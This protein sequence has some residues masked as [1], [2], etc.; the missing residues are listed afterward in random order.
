MGEYFSI[1]MS[2]RGYVYTWGMND[3]GQ[4]GI[5]SDVPYSFEPVAVSSSKSTLSKAVQ[6]IDCGL[7]HCLVLTKDYQLYSWGSNQLSQLGRKLAAQQNFSPQPGQVTAFEGTKPFKIACGSYHNICL[8]YRQPKQEEQETG[9]EE[10][11]PGVLQVLGQRS[12]NANNNGAQAAAGHQDDGCPHLES[13]TKLKGEIKR[14]RQE[15]IL[16]G[17]SK[18]RAGNTD[19][20]SEDDSAGE[21]ILDEQER[22]AMRIL[23]PDQRKIFVELEQAGANP[24][25]LKRKLK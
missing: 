18:R 11:T 13:I 7:K 25:Y 21:G 20:D 19:Y 3:K 10:N 14:L 22:A 17:P 4:L 12:Q 8:S 2:S 23:S 6:R 5:N 15:L 16:K 1:A 24:Q 9:P